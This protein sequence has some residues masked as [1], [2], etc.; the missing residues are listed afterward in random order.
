MTLYEAAQ[1]ILMLIAV[2]VFIHNLRVFS[3]SQYFYKRQKIIGVFTVLKPL[4]TAMYLFSVDQSTVVY[5]EQVLI[6]IGLVCSA[7]IARELGECP[8]SN[9]DACAHQC[10]LDKI[11][12][13]HHA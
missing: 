2:A 11:R 9:L 10:E 12:R 6:T 8:L 4:L 5:T 13:R 3:C 1:N 7:F